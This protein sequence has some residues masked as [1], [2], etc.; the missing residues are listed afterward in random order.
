MIK[1]GNKIVS[2]WATIEYEDGVCYGEYHAVDLN[3]A[4]AKEV[5]EDRIRSHEGFK[6]VLVVDV[7]KVLSVSKDAR[8]YFTDHGSENLKATAMIIGSGF[9]SMLANF[10]MKVNFKRPPI[11]VKMFKEKKEALIWVRKYL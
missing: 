9:N 3:L 1:Q 6:A 2:K 7:T 8:S 11:P 10:F 4:A 5:T